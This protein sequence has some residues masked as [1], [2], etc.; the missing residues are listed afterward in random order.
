[1]SGLLSYGILFVRTIEL[2]LLYS[3]FVN[4]K[5]LAGYT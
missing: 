3:G 2:T 5:L 4:L 1:M